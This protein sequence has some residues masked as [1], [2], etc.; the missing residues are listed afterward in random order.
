MWT[1]AVS[2]GP[3]RV[4]YKQVGGRHFG[5]NTLPVRAWLDSYSDAWALLGVRSEVWRLEEMAGAAS[6]DWVRSHPMRALRLADE[7]DKLLAVVGWIA[8][9][10]RPG[11]Y[12][13]QIDAPGVDTKFI[14]RHRGVLVE[15]LDRRLG[16]GRVDEAARDFAIRYGFARKPD[17][18]RFR[19]PFRG[20]S[21]ASVRVDELGSVPP[22]VSRVYVVENEI[23]YLA[24]PLPEKAMVIWGRGYAVDALAPL[25]W[26]GETDVVYWGDI[27]THGFAIL[28]RLRAMFP[29]VRSMLMDRETLL[30]HRSQWVR[31]PSPVIAVLDGLT[32]EEAALH[33]DLAGG[34]YGDRVR[35]EQE[36]VGF[37]AVER[38]IRLRQAV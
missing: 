6:G 34:V 22:G 23:T 38:A 15:L 13:R 25:R 2:R 36:R 37:G 3:L 32:A 10:Q 18:V 28:S 20:L 21:E 7:W 9:H 19:C 35:L 33:T 17:Y 8:E 12:L 26:L 11:M 24:F 27:D 5:T 30:A 1:E 29:G 4:D 16:P 31:E 14:E